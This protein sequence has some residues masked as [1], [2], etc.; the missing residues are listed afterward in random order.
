MEILGTIFIFMIIFFL[1]LFVLLVG[2]TVYVTIA[3]VYKDMQEYA[4]EEKFFDKG[5]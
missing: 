5:E 4:G 2:F 1:I 3:M